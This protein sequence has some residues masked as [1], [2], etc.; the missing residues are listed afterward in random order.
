MDEDTSID[1]DYDLALQIACGDEDALRTLIGEHG[2]RVQNFLKR[3]FPQIWEDALQDSLIRLVDKINLY[4]PQQ[5]PLGPWF[6]KLAQRCALSIVRAEKK[7]HRQEAHDGIERDERRPPEEPRTKRQLREE[8]R[9]VEQIRQSVA[10]LP[11]KERRVIEADLVSWQGGALPDEVASAD[12]LAESWG[13]TSAN[14][15]HQARF[16]GRKKLREDLIR[17]GVFREDTR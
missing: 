11:P 10:S 16:R 13:D 6:L 4:D 15:I 17:R 14:A 5:G 2:P 12:E 8:Q 3:Q 7:H 9:R 1:S